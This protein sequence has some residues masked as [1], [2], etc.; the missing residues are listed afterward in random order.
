MW[1]LS[2][3]VLI[4]W[5]GNCWQTVAIKSSSSHDVALFIQ[6]FASQNIGLNKRIGYTGKQV[7]RAGTTTDC[8]KCCEKNG[9]KIAF[10]ACATYW[11]QQNDSYINGQGPPLHI[12][13]WIRRVSKINSFRFFNIHGQR[14]I[15]KGQEFNGASPGSESN[16]LKLAHTKSNCPGDS[17]K[18]LQDNS[19]LFSLLQ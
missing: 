18:S 8:F 11:D 1:S 7:L 14:S 15:A 6:I 12:L 3:T 16:I 5:I 9:L 19:T 4:I 10:D 2:R 13:P 17:P